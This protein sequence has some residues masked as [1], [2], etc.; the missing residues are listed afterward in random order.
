MRP[1]EQKPQKGLIGSIVSTYPTPCIGK[2]IE[3][4]RYRMAKGRGV[5]DLKKE[6][7]YFRNNRNQTN[8][9]YGP[10]HWFGNRGRGQQ[11]SCHST[12][13]TI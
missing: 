3:A 10:P 11:S 9:Q 7:T 5:K 12:N 1:L 2:V 8:W 6:L 13:E 4:I